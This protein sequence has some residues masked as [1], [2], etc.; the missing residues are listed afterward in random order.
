MKRFFFTA[1]A[2][3]AV[4]VGCTKSN[5]MEA[6][7]SFQSPI[8]F[9]PYTGKAPATK[10][11]IMNQTTLEALNAKTTPAFHVNAF[12]AAG[13]NETQ[14]Y[15]NTYMNKDVWCKTPTTAAVTDENGEETTPA[16]PAT[17]TYD[18]ATYWPDGKSL[19]FVAYGLNSDKSFGA[20]ESNAAGTE[21]IVFDT[22]LPYTKFTYN[23]PPK[24]SEQE[25]LIVAA[26]V[27]QEGSTNTTVGLT[28][29]H[30]LSKI[31]FTLQTDTNNDVNVTIKSIVL[32]GQFYGSGTV[33]M[34]ATAPTVTRPST[35]DVTSYSLFDTQYTKG[36]TTGSYDVFQ[37]KS[38]GTAGA[39][40]Y[41]NKTLAL[42]T[43]EEATTE[44]YTAKSG[45]T[46][47]NRYMMLIP[48]TPGTANAK[49]TIEVIY[50]LTDADEQ[51]A[52]VELPA[53]F[54]FDQG[55]G[56]EF[57]LK[58]STKKVDFSVTVTDW[59][60]ATGMKESYTLTPVIE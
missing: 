35:A 51:K 39:A 25:D 46:E 37:I 9:E 43:S 13:T 15:T 29:G 31:G 20:T 5:I 54:K 7:Q 12:L 59:T 22:T 16:V 17:W 45:A 57:V 42:T 6:P 60:P 27:T 18:G 8:S 55:L 11:E 58:V 41:A 19:I 28:F 23:V 10:A 14:A 53:D 26:P 1:I 2:L 24:V 4:A 50:Q 32:K 40:I 52:I 48:C 36:A 56:Y 3:A 21:A 38:P 34:T 49:A 33:D 30:M 44:T 47:A